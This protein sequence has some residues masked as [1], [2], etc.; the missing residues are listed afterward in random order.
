MAQ[1]ALTNVERHSHARRVEISFTGA[2]NWLLLRI[3]D[4]GGG[5]RD[6][7]SRPDGG[8]GLRN[9]RERISRFGGML[10]VEQT[11]AGVRIEAR[12]P[13]SLIIPEKVSAPAARQ[14]VEAA[15]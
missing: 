8:L 9:M 13:R 12:L 2:G 6:T 14:P 7:G 3:E 5:F 15:E 4:D 10:S 11:D 1:E